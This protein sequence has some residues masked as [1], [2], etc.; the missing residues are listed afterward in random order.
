MQNPAK[1]EIRSFFISREFHENH[2]HGDPICAYRRVKVRCGTLTDYGEGLVATLPIGATFFFK[3]VLHLCAMKL[4]PRF[5]TLSVL[6]L[7]GAVH[8]ESEQEFLTAAQL[9]YQKGDIATAK[10]NFEM[11]YKMNPRNVTAIGYLK[12][13]AA[14]ANKDSGAAAVEKAL[15]ALIIPQIQFKEAT[16]GSALDFMRRKAEELS[17][18][19]QPVNFVVQ[20]GIDKAGTTVTLSLREVPFTEALRYVGD[21]ANVSFE[22]QKYAVVVKPKAGGASP[23]TR[24]SEDTKPADEKLPGQ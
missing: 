16:L 22:Y 3:K 13:I 5:I 17:G 14:T 6:A 4:L 10:R 12:T 7:A 19:K 9:A 2:R 24:P 21:L 1:M 23:A 18:G 8:A 20:P 15:S 11:V